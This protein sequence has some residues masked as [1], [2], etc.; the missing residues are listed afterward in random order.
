MKLNT[1]INE[2]EKIQEYIGGEKSYNKKALNDRGNR[3]INK[4]ITYLQDNY[5]ESVLTSDFISKSGESHKNYHDMVSILKGL[6]DV[7]GELGLL[8]Y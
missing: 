7:E 3:W 6:K 1:L 8:D 5:P 2:G 4:S